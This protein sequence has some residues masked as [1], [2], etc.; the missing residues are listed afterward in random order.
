MKVEN[1]NLKII[2]PGDTITD[3]L[4]NGVLHTVYNIEG[5]GLCVKENEVIYQPLSAFLS[6]HPMRFVIKPLN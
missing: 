4:F 2:E 5:K 3:N 1:F 6:K